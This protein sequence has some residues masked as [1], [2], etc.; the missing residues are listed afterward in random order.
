MLKNFTSFAGNSLLA[1]AILLMIVT[2]DY[3]DFIKGDVGKYILKI[4][5]SLVIIAMM[6]Y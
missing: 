1:V 5:L 3:F 2:Q 6:T 4:V